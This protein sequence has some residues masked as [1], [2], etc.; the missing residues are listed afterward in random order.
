MR[1]DRRRLQL[2]ALL[3]A[4]VVA[5]YAPFL[6]GGLLTDDFLHLQRIESLPRAAAAFTAPDAFGFYRP[7]TQ[8]S[9]AFDAAIH[10]SAAAGF[11][12]TNLMIHAAV[13]GLAFAVARLVLRSSEAAALAALAFALTPKAHP[14]A[15]SWISARGE[16][17]MS[18]WSLV[19]ALGVLQWSRDGRR[20][21]WWLAAIGYLLAITSKETAILLPLLLLLP[22][23]ERPWR[24]RLALLGVLAAVAAAVFV[25]RGQVGAML[26]TTA[27]G[28]Y[29][30][31]TPVDTWLRNARNYGARMLPGPLSLVVIGGLGSLLL[32][33]PRRSPG[34]GV[35]LVRSSPVGSGFSRTCPVLAFSLAWTALFIAPVLPIVLRSELYLYL[36]VFGLCVAAAWLVGALHGDRAPLRMATVVLLTAALGGYQGWRSFEH[37]RDLVFSRA[38]VEALAARSELDA[39][40]GDL[41]LTPADAATERHL[42]DAIGDYLPV[43]LDRVHGLARWRGRVEYQGRPPAEG[44]TLRFVCRYRDGRVLLERVS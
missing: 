39:A 5:A 32:H 15:V 26:P 27:D 36:P 6:G 35:G 44:P 18:L 11:R 31:A 8:A 20:G 43:V 33:G 7:I 25:W 23:L 19:A 12:A 34:A 3:I 22:G 13:I 28:H 2:L 21:W 1:S 9:L 24:P 38:L 29:A 37:H 4:L 14:A 30:L 16:L 17:L 40:T 41:T 10:G 42:R